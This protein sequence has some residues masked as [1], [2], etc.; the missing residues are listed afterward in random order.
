MKKPCYQKCIKCGK[1]AKGICDYQN[2]KK[3]TKTKIVSFTSISCFCGFKS[4]E[5][6]KP[7]ELMNDYDSGRPDGKE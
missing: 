5:E 4:T 3:N 6:R 7:N 1:S 2:T